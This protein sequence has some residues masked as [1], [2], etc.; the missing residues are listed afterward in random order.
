M[1]KSTPNILEYDAHQVDS[2][3]CMLYIFSNF[4][5]CHPTHTII[6]FIILFYIFWILNVDSCNCMLLYIFS[7]KVS[8]T[9]HAAIRYR[10]DSSSLE[11]P[12]ARPDD[13]CRHH[14][15]SRDFSDNPINP[16]NR[17]LIIEIILRWQ[18]FTGG[19]HRPPRRS[20]PSWTPSCSSQRS[21]A[22]S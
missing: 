11:A 9:T 19:T 6:N 16:K 7:K 3:N 22:S 14:P 15:Q 4:G 10:G 5:S 17:E 18:L 12:N 2:C 21:L 1:C 8:P 13:C 20:L